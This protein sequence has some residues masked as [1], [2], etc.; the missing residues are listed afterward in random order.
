MKREKDS[1]PVLKIEHMNITFTQYDK[2]MHQTE[3]P[4]IRDL[5]VEVHAGRWSL[6]SAPAAPEKVFWRMESWECC[7][8]M[9]LWAGESLTAGKS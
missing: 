2:G 7:P 3:L 9:P 6:S 4:V 8:I 1:I 5:D